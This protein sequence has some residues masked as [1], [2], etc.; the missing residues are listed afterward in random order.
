MIK[1]RSDHG[2]RPLVLH[3][4]KATHAPPGPETQQVWVKRLGDEDTAGGA[5]MAVLVVNAGPTNSR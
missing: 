1:L 3:L 5:P 4:C 2:L